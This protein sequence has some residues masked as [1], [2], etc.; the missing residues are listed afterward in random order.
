MSSFQAG[1]CCTVLPLALHH[2]GS[3]YLQCVSTSDVFLCLLKSKPSCS[4]EVLPFDI[5]PVCPF[6][7]TSF[8]LPCIIKAAA[9]GMHASS[10]LIFCNCC[11][12]L[13]AQALRVVLQ[14]LPQLR[15]ATK[16]LPRQ[17]DML[18]ASLSFTHVAQ[19]RRNPVPYQDLDEA[20]RV[21]MLCQGC[22]QY[23]E[24]VQ[25]SIFLTYHGRGGGVGHV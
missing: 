9:R 21:S 16:S 5:L 19:L 6:S 13:E 4:G 2:E 8:Y 18:Y 14:L 3:Q 10:C 11:L 23:P 22:M 25:L 20:S 24:L 7:E 17:Q 1:I 12:Q 15:C